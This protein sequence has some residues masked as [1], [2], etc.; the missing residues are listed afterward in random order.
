MSPPNSADNEP[1]VGADDDKIDL[2]DT[3][4]T[5]DE[6]NEDVTTE[7]AQANKDV[8]DK[9]DKDAKDKED[10]DKEIKLVGDEEENEEEYDET[11]EEENIELIL[12]PKKQEILK[13]YPDLFK[14]FPG[15]ERAFFK[16]RQY[17]E[18]VPTIK[19]ARTAVA[20]SEQLGYFEQELSK[21]NI[22]SILELVN[23]NDP[24]SFGR[25]IDEY[26]PAL[27]RTNQGAYLHVAKSF[28]HTFI[29]GMIGEAN[30]HPN[31][32]TRNT[33]KSAAQVLNQWVTGSSTYQKPGKFGKELPQQD[34]QVSD[35]LK[36]EREQFEHQKFTSVRDDLDRKVTNVLKNTISENIDRNGKMTAFTK[37][38]AIEKCEALI[39][40]RMSNDPDFK[41]NM[42]RLWDNAVR[43]NYSQDSVNKVKAAFLSVART[44][45]PDAIKEI[46][47]RV[48]KG[49]IG[50]RKVKDREGLL[51]RGGPATD[52]RKDEKAGTRPIRS[53]SNQRIKAAGGIKA[54]MERD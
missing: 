5:E 43:H 15:L 49:N 9:A 18:V 16:E 37:D 13:A 46:R 44:H 8:L 22:A 24:D 35:K 39:N 47:N 1:V 29:E 51:R 19:D 2:S 3:E 12:T 41:R 20:R 28:A 27:Q 32:E 7:T 34:Q 23:K 50:E 10:E 25:I 42:T 21:G 31:E 17:A 26:I 14:K 38:A 6:E 54:F 48:L 52:G 33:L 30:A 36:Q 45:L 53:E 4:L 40:Q 11:K